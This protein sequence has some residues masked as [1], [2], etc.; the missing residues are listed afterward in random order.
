M[1]IS[2]RCMNLVTVYID[3]IVAKVLK[4]TIGCYV[5]WMCLSILLYADDIILLAPSITALQQL[6]Q[7]CEQELQWLDMSINV[8]KSACMRV[9]PRFNA[10]CH[11]I[12]T[13]EGR[14]LPWVDNIR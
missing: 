13:A 1:F 2:S 6:L 4:S 11:N 9:G 5:K 12:I 3:S 7:V 14:E 10:K 8:K